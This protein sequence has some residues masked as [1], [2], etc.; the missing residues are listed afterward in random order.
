LSRTT[1][2]RFS[3]K[4]LICDVAESNADELLLGRSRTQSATMSVVEREVIEADV[5]IGSVE[6]TEN[7]VRIELTE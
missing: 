4:K 2:I 7:V 5:V 1:T 3:A 6:C